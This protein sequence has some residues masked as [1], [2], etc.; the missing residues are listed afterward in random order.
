MKDTRT[1]LA[2]RPL[3]DFIPGSCSHPGA[4]AVK[5]HVRGVGGEARQDAVRIPVRKGV[6]LHRVVGARRHQ[7]PVLRTRGWCVPGAHLPNGRQTF[8]T[9]DPP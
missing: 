5:G 9:F 8:P 6:D 1:P 3:L 7:L 2:L 4:A